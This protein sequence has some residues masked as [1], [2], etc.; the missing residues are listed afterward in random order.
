MSVL[1]IEYTSSFLF[2]NRE[3]RLG[4]DHDNFFKIFFSFV[5]EKSLN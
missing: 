4:L 5:L 1:P 3:F 2:K